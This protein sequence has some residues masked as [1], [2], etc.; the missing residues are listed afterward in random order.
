MH[1]KTL[2]LATFLSLGIFLAKSAQA[3]CPVCTI[4]ICAGIGFS[5]W[6]GID[7]SISGIW[8]GGLVVSLI[9]W[10]LSWFNKKGIH[11]MFRGI[12]VSAIFYLLTILP[13]YFMN[14]IGHPLNK[15]WG[16]DKI[17]FGT[18]VGTFIFLLGVLLNNLLKKRNQGRPFFPYQKVVFPVSF[19]IITSLIFHFII[20][21]P[22]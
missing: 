5:R 10:A 15:I 4:A 22:K 14:I 12:I 16:V 6:I 19:L 13:L 8:I 17:L 11:F 21:C 2:T 1:R 3:V 20:K 9:V 18:V 7:D